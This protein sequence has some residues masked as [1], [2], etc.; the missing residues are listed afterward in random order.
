M[1]MADAV[2]RLLPGV[3]GDPQSAAQDSFSRGLLDYPQYTKPA[4]FRG[5]A[6]PAV[7]LSGD[8]GKIEAWRRQQALLRTARRRPELLA[9]IELSPSERE[10]L[11]EH[12]LLNPEKQ[13][14]PMKGGNEIESD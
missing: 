8:H 12:Q 7:L 13:D 9:G 10:F 3:L 4:E 5:M 14:L 2:I 6:V 1:V 11:E